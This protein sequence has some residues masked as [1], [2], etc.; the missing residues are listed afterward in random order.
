[1]VLFDFSRRFE[2]GV[3]YFFS[4]NTWQGIEIRHT[5][6]GMSVILHGTV[7][8]SSWTEHVE[9]ARIP[10]LGGVSRYMPNILNSWMI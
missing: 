7:W 6:L 10:P 3:G 5:G 2:A 4:Q 1:M 9:H 8:S